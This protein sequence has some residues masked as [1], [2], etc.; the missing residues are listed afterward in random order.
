MKIRYIILPFILIFSILI[1]S[2][3]TEIKKKKHTVN[4]I[5]LITQISIQKQET[6]IKKA[7][8]KRD[9]ITSITELNEIYKKYKKKDTTFWIE[10]AELINSKE[11]VIFY[12]RNYFD[13]KNQKNSNYYNFILTGKLK[14]SISLVNYESVIKEEGKRNSIAKDTFFFKNNKI[15]FWKNKQAT[16]EEL[17]KKEKEILAIKKEIDSIMEW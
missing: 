10:G 14:Q 9:S 12:S 1:A 2:C 6:L 11:K 8:L 13:S 3:K 5:N 7:L 15:Y 17:Q 4:K 16:K